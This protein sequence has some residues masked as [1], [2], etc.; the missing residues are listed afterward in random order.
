MGVSLSSPDLKKIIA[1][2]EE[3]ASRLEQSDVE[4]EEGEIYDERRDSLGGAGEQEQKCE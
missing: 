2:V 1:Y 3:A 4:D